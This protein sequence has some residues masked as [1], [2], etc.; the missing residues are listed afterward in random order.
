MMHRGADSVDGLVL[1]RLVED[2]SAR[3][4]SVAADFLDAST[5][6]S[7]RANALELDRAGRLAPAASDVSRGSRHGKR[8]C[9]AA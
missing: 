3:G 2:L 9:P 7:L 8:R 5:I 1:A 4:Y 6:A